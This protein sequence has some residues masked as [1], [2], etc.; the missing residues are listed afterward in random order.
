MQQTATWKQ[1]KE[2][3]VSDIYF[4]R[5]KKILEAKGI[6]SP[7]RVE[8]MA[9]KLPSDWNWAVFAGLEECMEILKDLPVEVRAMKEG[10]IFST[11]QPAMEISGKYLDFGK[12]ETALLG[13][14][15]QASGIATMAA[16]CKKAAGKKEV[17]SFGARRMHPIIAP[18]I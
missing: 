7:V 10:T 18:L 14:I 13:L 17:V 8:F 9:H 5:T 12:H 2:G 1:V 6:D 16:R 15:C 11:Q 4:D 3:L